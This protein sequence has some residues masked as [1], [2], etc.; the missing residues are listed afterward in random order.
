VPTPIDPIERASTLPSRLYVDPAVLETERERVFGRTWQLVARTADL[1]RPG[2]FVPVE[3]VGEP[4]VVVRGLEGQLRAFFNVCRH[5]AGQVAL[6]P[7]Q[8]PEPTVPLSR[9]DLRP[10]RPAPGRT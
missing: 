3:L 4:I 9:L 8:P 7:R 10:G 5:R 2:D 1:A 6:S